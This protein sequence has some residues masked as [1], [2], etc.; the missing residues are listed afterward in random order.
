[1]KEDHSCHSTD[2]DVGLLWFYPAEPTEPETQYI[3][4]THTHTFKFTDDW[5]RC[6]A[7]RVE[8]RLQL[9]P[10]SNTRPCGIQGR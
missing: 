5:G 1:M 2:S 9:D 8:Q 6:V 10:S 3:Y 7:Q 4:T